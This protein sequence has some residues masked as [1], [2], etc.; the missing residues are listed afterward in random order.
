MNKQLLQLYKNDPNK[1]KSIIRAGKFTK[2]FLKWNRKEIAKGNT[3]HY[4]KP[5][6]A[7]RIGKDG[8]TYE[9]KITKKLKKNNTIT[10]SVV[11]LKSNTL[12]FSYVYLASKHE[13]TDTLTLS[14]NMLLRELI[15]RNNIMTLARH[16]N[17]KL[18]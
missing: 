16:D 10:N 14:N 15:D 11:S 7:I 1:P 13:Y 6:T 9:S 3:T 18:S 12:H 4:A 8:R 5:N 2:A 17:K